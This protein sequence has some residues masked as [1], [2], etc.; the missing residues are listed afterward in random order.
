MNNNFFKQLLEVLTPIVL[1][2]II[3]LLL[4]RGCNLKDDVKIIVDGVIVKEPI[5]N[6]RA[7]FSGRLLTDDDKYN[8]SV[9]FQTCSD[10]EY[11]GE[12]EYPRAKLAFPKSHKSTFDG[13]AIDKNTRV[14]IYS[15]EDFKGKILMDETGPALINNIK[16]ENNTKLLEILIEINNKELNG[17]LNSIFPVSSRKLSNHDMHSFSEGSLKVICNE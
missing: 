12:G 17:K 2:T 15:Q 1:L 3:I 6:C 11:V 14:I 4:F 16:W 5:I 7:H 10:S 9:I 8:E 13:I